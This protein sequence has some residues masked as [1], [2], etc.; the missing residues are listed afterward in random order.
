MR[1]LGRLTSLFIG[2]TIAGHATAGSVVVSKHASGRAGIGVATLQAAR[3]ARS[4]PSLGVVLDPAPLIQLSG[5]IITDKAKVAAAKAK[6]VL[7]QQQMAQASALYQKKTLSLAGYQKAQEDLDAN[8]AALAAAQARRTARLARTEATWGTAMAAA[9][10]DN[11]DPLPQ[12][13]AGKEMLVGLSLSPGTVLA[14]P[15][16]HAE[17]EAAGARFALRLI[18][19]VSA[20]LGRYPG[21]SFLY[22]AAAQA[23]VPVGTT[24]SASLPAG[25]ERAGVTVPWSAVTWRDGRALVFRAGSGDRFEPVTIETDAPTADGYFVSGALSPGDRVVVRGAD[26]LLGLAQHAPSVG[27]DD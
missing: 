23:G 12:L 19:P 13:A 18:G 22:V 25:P 5:D 24:V 2:L 9:L 21:Q 27:D 3:V 15:P 10:R 20:M 11:S 16:Q 1:P 26:L 17:G 7:D 14:A 6:V 8:R 4:V